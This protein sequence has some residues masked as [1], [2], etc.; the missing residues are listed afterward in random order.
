MNVTHTPMHRPLMRRMA[1][2]AAMMALL[3]VGCYIPLKALDG[4]RLLLQGRSMITAW[5]STTCLSMTWCHWHTTRRTFH[6][7]P[8]VCRRTRNHLP[9][10]HWP[11]HCRPDAAVCGRRQQAAAGDGNVE[12]ARQRRTKTAHD[13]VLLCL[14]VP[15]CF[16]IVSALCQ[17]DDPG[18]IQVS[19]DSQHHRHWHRTVFGMCW[20][21]VL[22]VL[23]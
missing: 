5:L 6:R 13:F 19:A 20:C 9:L 15:L 8:H 3:R 7:R 18:R 11:D 22:C 4:T 10:G 1:V 2:T 17:H 16:D 21:V 23:L 14:Y 12:G